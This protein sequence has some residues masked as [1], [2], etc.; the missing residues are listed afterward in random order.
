MAKTT[1]ESKYEADIYYKVTF[2]RP[3][4]LYNTTYT[5]ISTNYFL[6]SVLEEIDPALIEEVIRVGSEV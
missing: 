6:G 4:T 1:Q 5:A 3:V 2:N